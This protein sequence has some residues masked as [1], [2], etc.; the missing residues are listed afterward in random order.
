MLLPDAPVRGHAH[1]AG[2]L[3]PEWKRQARPVEADILAAVG[4][5]PVGASA[6]G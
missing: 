4:R 6:L 3:A 1:E 5:E 2:R